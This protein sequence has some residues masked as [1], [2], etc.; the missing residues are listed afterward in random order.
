MSWSLPRGPDALGHWLWVQPSGAS[1]LAEV[2]AVKI[3]FWS[4]SDLVA[5]WSPMDSLGIVTT[6]SRSPWLRAYKSSR[7][8][9]ELGAVQNCFATLVWP[10]WNAA[11][12][13]AELQE[14]R[15]GSWSP[16]VGGWTTTTWTNRAAPL[17]QWRAAAPSPP[18]SVPLPSSV[19]RK[20]HHRPPPN[21]G[22]RKMDAA[23]PW[24]VYTAPVSEVYGLGDPFCH[25][26]DIPGERELGLH[27][28]PILILEVELPNTNNWTN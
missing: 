14:R 26:E 11:T 27:L 8:R 22:E 10:P 24:F 15:T 3:A 6:A 16:C 7:L 13:G 4:K 1:S 21:R 18:R 12:T 25:G 5:A 2:R 19:Q 17:R 28:F 23:A 20:C 9:G